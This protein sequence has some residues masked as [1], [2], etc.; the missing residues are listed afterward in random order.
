MD[1][2]RLQQQETDPYG[3]TDPWSCWYDGLRLTRDQVEGIAMSLLDQ[4]L[5]KGYLVR[6]TKDDESSI[7]VLSKKD[8]FP[9]IWKL[10]QEHDEKN[11]RQPLF[12]PGTMGG[13]RV[14]QMSGVKE[15]G[16]K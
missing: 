4:T 7:L 10:R 14:V 8:P 13:G 12:Q 15:I 2:Q 16:E 6:P 9:N 11:L 3:T 1:P 5:I